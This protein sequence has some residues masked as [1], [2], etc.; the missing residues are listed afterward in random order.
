MYDYNTMA[1]NSAIMPFVAVGTP[2]DWLKPALSYRLQRRKT[3]LDFLQRLRFPAR[4][5]LAVRWQQQVID[6]TPHHLCH[7]A[8]R[9]QRHVTV[10]SQD[11]I[12]LC[13]L[14][15][16]LCCKAYLTDP[17]S[18]QVCQHLLQVLQKFEPWFLRLSPLQILTLY[19]KSTIIPCRHKS[20]LNR[21]CL[22]IQS[23][24]AMRYDVKI[25]YKTCGCRGT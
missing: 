16:Y 4:D 25:I 13:R 24:R 21:E 5:Y 20:K 15:P 19:S 17:L 10:A 23:V 1:S 22:L 6:L 18:L 2:R 3:L 7:A 14:E 8:Q 12:Q 9:L 11:A